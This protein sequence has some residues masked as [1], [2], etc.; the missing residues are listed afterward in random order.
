MNPL[1]EI[2]SEC[3]A[4][5]I[6]IYILQCFLP[7]GSRQE[8]QRDRET[9]RHRDRET[10]RHRETERQRDTE[11]QRHR[12]TETQRQCKE[13]VCRVGDELVVLSSSTGW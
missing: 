10:Q 7:W 2:D 3:A 5:P 12:D 11:T 9:Q 8:R 1:R 4:V 6:F 13:P